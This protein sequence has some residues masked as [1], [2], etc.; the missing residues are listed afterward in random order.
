MC[1]TCSNAGFVSV[2]YAPNEDQSRP[3]T[4]HSLECASIAYSDL[5]QF[6][7]L[8][9]F[10]PSHL[11]SGGVTQRE[12][13]GVVAD[14]IG[15]VRSCAHGYEHLALSDFIFPQK[16]EGWYQPSGDDVPK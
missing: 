3:G 14:H 7:F 13:L 2:C 4:W 12:S 10:S 11:A 9:G 6:S 5:Q 16:R 15:T 1:L 8:W